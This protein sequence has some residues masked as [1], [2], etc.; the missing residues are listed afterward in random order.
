MK[1]QRRG[2]GL[3]TTAVRVPRFECSWTSAP[4]SVAGH[5]RSLG[6]VGAAHS[7]VDQ[8]VTNPPTTRLSTTSVPAK[9]QRLR[10]DTV[11][12]AQPRCR[13]RRRTSR[14]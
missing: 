13:H 2:S 9:K 12:S 3:R 4:A 8:V 5:V 11:P 1:S 6:V 10:L 7:E 14:V